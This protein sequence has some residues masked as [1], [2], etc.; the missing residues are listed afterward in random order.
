MTGSVLGRLAG[1]PPEEGR[2]LSCHGRRIVKFKRPSRAG[3]EGAPGVSTGAGMT[4][5]EEGIGLVPAGLYII[6]GAL[7]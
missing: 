1:P 5:L 3:A 2:S 7:S 4:F 6:F